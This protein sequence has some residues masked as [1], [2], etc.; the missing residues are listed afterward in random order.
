M[1]GFLPGG[2]TTSRKGGR[3]ELLPH[4]RGLRGEKGGG[5]VSL[6]SLSILEAEMR[7]AAGVVLSEPQAA[8]RKKPSE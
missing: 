7:V 1:L 6:L 8:G 5:S 2:G 4:L 3:L